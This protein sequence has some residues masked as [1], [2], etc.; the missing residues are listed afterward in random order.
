MAKPMTSRER[1]RRMFEHREADRVPVLDGPW[2]ATLE[3]WR[4]EGLPEGADWRDYFGLDK[5]AHIGVDNSPRFEEK[6]IEE[7]DEYRIAT[8]K[9]GATVKNW[10]HVA[11][12]PLDL[13]FRVKDRKA[14][15]E[16]KRRL[17]PTPDR[18]PWDH[19]KK[20][21]PT[22][23]KEGRWIEAGLWFGF[24]VSHSRMVGTERFLL[25]MIDDPEWC[26]ETFHAL[27][28]MDLALLD[29][30]WEAGYTWDCVSWPD[31]LGYKG[32]Q[33]FSIPMYRALLK[34]AHKR[35]ADWARAKGCKVRLHSCGNVNPYIPEFLDIGV[36]GLNP[37]EVKAGMDPVA[38]KRQYGDRLLL[39]G[40]INAVLWD[41]R[42]AI[43]AE[44]ERVV[45]RLKERG[46][47]IFASDH[48]IP[49]AV[50]L[51]DFRHIIATVKRVGAY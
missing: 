49:S 6:V 1:F 5:T 20:N 9:F 29:M 25:A 22:W 18:I 47:Y 17:T 4:R 10:K 45:P 37:L 24:D 38:V 8:T 32:H 11:S 46:G 15:Q 31:D 48:S 23:R 21:Y 36:D 44:I 42:D 30:V 40:G 13:D 34:P 51:E 14:W 16:A 39:H 3:R 41:R 27:L 19:L 35:A 7:T 33:F 43:T 50:S 26:A 2:A 28:D 12:T